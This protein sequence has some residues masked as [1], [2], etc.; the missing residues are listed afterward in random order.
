MAQFC[1]LGHLH[2]QESLIHLALSYSHYN[3]K[4]LRMPG[5]IF[6][7]ITFPNNTSHAFLVIELYLK[8]SSQYDK[9]LNAQ[10]LVLGPNLSQSLRVDLI[11]QWTTVLPC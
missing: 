6:F 10:T 11:A 2:V 5:S 1:V 8:Q 4:C 7:W 3:P 9:L